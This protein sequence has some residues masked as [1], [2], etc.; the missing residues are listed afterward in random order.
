VWIFCGG[1]PRSGSTLQFQLTAH[2]IERAGLGERVEWVRPEEFPRLRTKYAGRAGWKVFK[3]H[4]CTPEIRAEFG[5]NNTKG[6]YVYRDVRD[7][8]VSRMRK[9][10]QTFDRLWQGGVLD[11][12]L[13]G[14][15]RWTSIN[16]VLVSR[17]ED[18]V[19]DP[20]GEVDQIA[21]YLGIRIRRDECEDVASQYTVAR[22]LERIREA[23]AAGR[24]EHRDGFRY[25]PSSNLH[26]DHIRSGKSGEWRHVLTRAQVALIE[27]RAKRW[28]LANG[29]A[30]SLPS[31]Q[32]VIL[33]LGHGRW[34]RRRQGADAPRVPGG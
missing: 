2:L 1:M 25:D 28:L 10:D 27:E 16:G 3:T 24:L 29:Y 7:V 9:R 32:R 31:W 12:L 6:V 14:F 23:E 15:D 11:N 22:Q 34:Q 19:V 4:A 8:V 20:A 18:M 26:V 13:S 17:Y 5:T 30:L 33:S 21:R